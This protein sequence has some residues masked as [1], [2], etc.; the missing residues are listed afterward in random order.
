MLLILS[1]RLSYWTF[2]ISEHFGCNFAFP[3]PVEEPPPPALG[4]GGGCKGVPS[5]E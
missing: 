1:S 5:P 4:A 3:V 2:K